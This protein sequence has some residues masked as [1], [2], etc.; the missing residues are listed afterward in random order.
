ML[1][2]ICIMIHKSTRNHPDFLYYQF[3]SRGRNSVDSGFSFCRFSNQPMREASISLNTNIGFFFFFNNF[4]SASSLAI[5]Q[6]YTHGCPAAFYRKSKSI[7]LSVA[8]KLKTVSICKKSYTKLLEF[9]HFQCF[10]GSFIT[11]VL[12]SLRSVDKWHIPSSNLSCNILVYLSPVLMSSFPEE[13]LLRIFYPYF[14]AIFNCSNFFLICSINKLY[15]LKEHK[16]LNIK[17]TP[18]LIILAKNSKNHKSW[19]T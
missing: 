2:C 12:Y 18:F 17:K 14:I 1:F 4:F 19:E 13:Y 16:I 10:E 7:Y 9:P 5:F 3:I 11:F 15:P 6:N 8:N